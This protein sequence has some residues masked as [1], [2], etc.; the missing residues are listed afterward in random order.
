MYLHY[1]QEQTGIGL[2]QCDTGAGCYDMERVA[3]FV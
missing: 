2:R 1:S 3:I